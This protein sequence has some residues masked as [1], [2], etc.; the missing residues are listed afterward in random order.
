MIKTTTLQEGI[1]RRAGVRLVVLGFALAMW[2]AIGGCSEP[3]ANQKRFNS[4]AV[5][6]TEFGTDFQLTDDTGKVRKLS[7][8]RGKVV[9]V[10]FGYTHCPDACPTTLSELAAI[11]KRLGDDGNRLQVL[12]V[13]VDPERDTPDVLRGYVP[14]F[15]PSF[16][17]LYSD[18]ETTRKVASDFKVFYEKIAGSGATNYTIDHSVYTYAFDA[19]GRLRLLMP[20]TEPIEQKL[21]DIRALLAG[22]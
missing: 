20:P 7:E 6:S 14:A 5:T 9:T 11:T 8:F 1:A 17:G 13:T 3:A 4:T 22:A 21:A 2:G 10:F 16:V 15:N 18:A 19:R 12:F